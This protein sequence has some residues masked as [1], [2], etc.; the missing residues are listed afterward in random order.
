MVT[1]KQ[2]LADI[3]K[4]ERRLEDVQVRHKVVISELTDARRKL[5]EYRMVKVKERRK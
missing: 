4:W 3:K 5:G 1:E 2:L